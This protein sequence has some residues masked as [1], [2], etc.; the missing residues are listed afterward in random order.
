MGKH[1][2]LVY[3]AC[4][5]A[6]VLASPIGMAADSPKLPNPVRL[7]L[8]APP[9]NHVLSSRQIAALTTDVAANSPESQTVMGSVTV[10]GSRVT[11]ACCGTFIAVPWALTHPRHAWRIFTPVVGPCRGTWCANII[12]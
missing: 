7:D 8:R 6:L 5:V 12:N 11:P 10:T 3:G 2:H 4:L 9:P 1:E